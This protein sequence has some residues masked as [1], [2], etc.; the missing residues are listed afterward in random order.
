M[1]HPRN[2]GEI[3]QDLQRILM[4]LPLMNDHRQ[5][6]LSGQS[7]LLPEAENLLLPGYIL[8]VIIQAN[9]PN[10]FDLGISLRQIPVFLQTLI[11]DLV[12]RIGMG[13]YSGINP[14]NA[15]GQGAGSLGGGQITAGVHEK[16]NSLLREPGQ[17]LLPVQVKPAVI[18][19]GMGIK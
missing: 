10:G 15:P 2:L 7:H 1:K 3:C 5:I 11:P 13:A 17:E 14:V 18:Q 19:M 4:R 9:L 6:Q 16:P 12:R 8:I